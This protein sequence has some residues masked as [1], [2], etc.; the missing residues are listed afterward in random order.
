MILKY[1]YDWLI[2][3]IILVAVFISFIK[4][5]YK[6]F[7]N[8]HSLSIRKLREINE[9]F[10][11]KDIDEIKFFESF[12]NKHYYS[13]LSPKDLLVY[14]LEKKMKFVE[15]NISHAIYNSNLYDLYMDEVTNVKNIGTYDVEK[16]AWFKKLLLKIEDE[17]FNSI[18]LNPVRDY[19]IRTSIRLT[20]I[21]GREIITKTEYFGVVDIE[22]VIFKLKQKVNDRY[23][24]RETWDA[25]CRIERAKVTNR[26]RFAIYKRDKYRCCKCG[27]KTDDLEIDHIMP[28]AKGGKTHPNN[29]Q[30][31]CKSCNK[32]KS[33]IIESGTVLFKDKVNRRCPK[34]GAPLKKVNGKYGVF[35]GCMNYPN[36]K[37]TEKD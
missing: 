34:C 16:K 29:L 27:R 2:Y 15:E 28:I 14:R 17:K 36:C 18:I 4:I 20:D 3:L 24:D 19:S 9:K 8:K 13:T 6:F 23:N 1:N 35:Y 32:E 33:D 7:V 10:I 11:F 30:T 21:N 5:K 31:L 25:I 12:D 26:I 22:E 37:Y